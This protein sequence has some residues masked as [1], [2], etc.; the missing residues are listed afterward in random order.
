MLHK[1]APT[2]LT[3]HQECDFQPLNVG[4]ALQNGYNE[5]R[6]ASTEHGRAKY[7][8]FTDFHDD[9]HGQTDGRYFD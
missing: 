3:Y 8:L 9:K 5:T 7:P 6:N 2:P 4:I 1:T